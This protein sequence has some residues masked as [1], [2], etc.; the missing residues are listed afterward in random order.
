MQPNLDEHVTLH[1]T[2]RELLTSSTAVRYHIDNTPDNDAIYANMCRVAEALE[3]I[4][5]HFD[6]PIR[7]ISCFRAPAVNIVCGGSPTSA[8]K[9][10]SA[11]DFT[12]QG[13]ANIEVCRTIPL[14]FKDWDQ[15]IYEFGPEG[16]IH[17]GLAAKPRHD[18]L[19]AV[20]V[21]GKTAYKQG[22]IAV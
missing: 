15:I 17:L 3:V 2:W 13:I 22:I 10:G 19:T 8:H 1:F 7:V 16:W 14:I 9:T 5:A 4:R 20:K 21:E 18:E 6:R 12:V 11:A